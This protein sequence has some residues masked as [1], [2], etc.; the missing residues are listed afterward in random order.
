MFIIGGLEEETKEK[1]EVESVRGDHR[2]RLKLKKHN[3]RQNT[4]Y[5]VCSAPGTPRSNT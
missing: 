4:L 2:L 1:K 3:Q 5:L